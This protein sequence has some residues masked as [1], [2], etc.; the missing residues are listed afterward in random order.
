MSKPVSE[1][2]LETLTSP[3]KS[4]FHLINWMQGLEL[5]HWSMQC[6]HCPN[7]DMEFKKKRDIA[8]KFAWRCPVPACRSTTSIRAGSIFQEFPKVSLAI[9]MRFIQ[10]WCEDKLITEIQ[11]ELRVVGF[12]GKKTL[13]AMCRLMRR[14]CDFKL[15]DVPVV[16]MGGASAILEMDESCFRKT[17]KYGRGRRP[18]PIWVFGIVQTDVRPAI[19]YMT[20]VER[21]DQATLLPIIERC[22]LPGSTIHSDQWAAYRNVHHLPNIVHHGTVNHSQNFVDPTTGVHTQHI[23]AYWS[24]KKAKLRRMR[25]C[26]PTDLESYLKEFMWRERYCRTSNEGLQNMLKYITEKYCM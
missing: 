5:L 11:N 2:D 15:I 23:E 12:V 14:L 9:W 18:K 8:D 13:S 1:L 3:N 16:P 10:K 25:G 21:R 6:E 4:I 26:L 20:V 7:V 24:R 19:G 22:V 17:P